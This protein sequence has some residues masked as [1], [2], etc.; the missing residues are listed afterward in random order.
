MILVAKFQVLYKFLDYFSKFD[1][2]NYCISLTGPVHVSSLPEII[3]EICYC[4]T[5]LTFRG[6]LWY[7]VN[8]SFFL[9]AE[10]PEDGGKG[11][12]LTGDF[13]RNRFDMLHVLSRIGETN[14]RMFQ[15]KHLIIVDPLKEN[16]NL[17]S[18]VNEGSFLL[19][20]FDTLNHW[21]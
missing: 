17:G 21:K 9:A 8:G 16:N 15:K 20:G 13:L 5:G 1:W 19:V 4:L 6:Q 7:I 10:T 11:L 18:S 3:G 2:K 12:L 14:L